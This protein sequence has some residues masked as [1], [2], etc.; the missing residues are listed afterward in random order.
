MRV[1]VVG[2]GITGLSLTHHLAQRGVDVVTFEAAAEPGGVVRSE[3][4]DGRVLEYGPQRLRL[5]DPIEDLLDD[6]GLSDELLVADESAPLY[7]YVDGRLRLVPRSVGGFLRTDV[8]SWRGKL[9][10]LAEPVTDPPRDDEHAAAVFE[11]KFG[12]EAYE[13]VIAPLFGGTY[14]SDPAR[15]PA[16]YA[17][18]PLSALE[19][20]HGSLLRAAAGRLLGPGDVA[21]P[22]SFGDGLQQ[23]PA[24]LYAAH[25]PY[26][27]LDTAVD[28]IR[29]EGEG[30][31]LLETRGRTTTVDVVV[32]TVP[33]WAAASLL[34][35]LEGATAAPLAE[36]SYNSL[37][38]VH[39][40]AALDREGFGYQ[41]APRA[42]IRTLGVTWNDAM[43]GR[44]GVSTAFLG[45]MYDSEILE[46]PSDEIG[47]I[48]SREFETVLGVDPSVLAVTELPSVIPA[49]DTTWHGLA[50]VSLP[51]TVVLAANYIDRLGIGARVRQAGDVADRLAERD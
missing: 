14:G 12:R 39:L 46:L 48:A 16:E 30:G 20:R 3:R 36:L 26:V 25:A 22:V 51:E 18:E 4:V 13:N 24:A 32:L 47:A 35:E 11:R 28:A 8:L 19:T 15:M 17:L 50:E 34:A 7:V 21:P 10:L 43:F 29:S 42:S 33:A 31:Y 49:Y 9:R 1:G 45:G 44:D 27:H 41:V 5:S 38:L 6:L 37:A 2:A 23:L 40:D